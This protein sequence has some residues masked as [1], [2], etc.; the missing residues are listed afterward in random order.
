MDM[1]HKK[2]VL[3]STYSVTQQF[4][5]IFS[6]IKEKFEDH[7]MSINENTNEIQAN[8]EYLCELDTKIE[9]LNER[10][11]QM[12]I[13]L[14]KHGLEVQEKPDF[15]IASLTKRE[16]EVFLVLYTLDGT[17]DKITYADVARRTGLTE[18]LAMGYIDN[19]KRKGVPIVR[20]HKHSK[21]YLKLNPYFR[22]LQAKQNIL[23]LDQR[24]L[25]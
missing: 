5:V 8:C 7:L 14:Q 16:Q 23:N 19:I 22:T 3:S 1:I 2:G 9:K 24:T 4:K 15:K 21:A 11:D 17:K 6:Q 13:F 18:E 25:V 10:L 20:K 12:Q